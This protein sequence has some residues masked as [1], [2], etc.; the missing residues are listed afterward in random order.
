MILARYQFQHGHLQ[1]KLHHGFGPN[2]QQGA[3]ILYACVSLSLAFGSLCTRTCVYLCQGITYWAIYPVKGEVWTLAANIY[4][5]GWVNQHCERNLGTSSTTVLILHYS[6]LVA[7]FLKFIPF[8]H[9]LA[10][11]TGRISGMN[12]SPHTGVG[13]DVITDIYFF[14]LLLSILHARSL[15]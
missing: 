8:T 4:S 9:S 10:T 5:W 15:S 1:Y 2:L 11:I 6:E 13:C 12:D 7:S 3:G 14:P